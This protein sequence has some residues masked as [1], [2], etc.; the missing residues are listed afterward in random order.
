M[1]KP[2]QYARVFGKHF[3]L[4]Y[5]CYST[6]FSVFN[7]DHTF[8]VNRIHI[9]ASRDKFTVKCSVPLFFQVLRFID[10]FTPAAIHLQ[11]VFLDP[12][13]IH[14]EHIIKAV[15][16]FFGVTEE[17]L[18][19]KQRSRDIALPR[20]IAM[21]LIREETGASLPQIGEALGGRDHTT[22]LYG[23]DK[24]SDQLETDDALR[25]QVFSI[26]ETLY[27]QDQLVV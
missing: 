9:G 12:N 7:I 25:R 15:A 14:I 20:Q 10:Q 1:K 17:R 24:I 21:Y 26:K 4:S 19:G 23:Y 8:I 6:F 3:S 11:Q 22:I 16:K 2:G 27:N 13:T 18:L 5:Y